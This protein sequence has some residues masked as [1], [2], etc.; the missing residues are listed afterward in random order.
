MAAFVAPSPLN[1]VAT[2]AVPVAIGIAVVR[3]RL[4]GIDVVLNRTLVGTA[5]L[6]CSALVYVA[7]VGWLGGIA[8]ALDSVVGFVGPSPWPPFFPH[9]LYVR[10]Q[11]AVDRLLHG[12]RAI[13]T[14][15]GRVT[16]VL[17]GAGSPRQALTEAVA[18]IAADLKLP[19]VTVRVDRLGAPPVVESVGDPGRAV[20][21][22]PL[23]WHD[24]V[25]GTLSVAH[26]TAPTP[27]S[28]TRR[29]SPTWPRRSPPWASRCG[30]ATDLSAR[31]TG[32]SPPARRSAGASAVTCTTPWARS[33]RRPSWPWTSPARWARTSAGLRRS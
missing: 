33:S 4:F 27:R 23:H 11:R 26:R 19:A 30:S 13:P 31:A 9:P 14:A 18:T 1:L 8:G 24:D 32:W 2:L 12:H 20:H 10:I 16:E 22:F 6:A 28:W 3:H 21:D 17:R 7:V 15:P 25:V 29:C 5:L